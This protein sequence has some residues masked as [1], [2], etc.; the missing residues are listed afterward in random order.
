MNVG[1]S[2]FKCENIC[3][4]VYAN[5][6]NIEMEKILV[7]F[8][9]LVGAPNSAVM[10]DIYHSLMA[11]LRSDVRIKQKQTEMHEITS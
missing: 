3:H 8:Q 1:Q 10:H 9:H 4:L 11:L 2:S 5:L 6:D 7:F